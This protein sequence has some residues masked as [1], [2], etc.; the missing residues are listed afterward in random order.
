MKRRENSKLFRGDA[1]NLQEPNTMMTVK[2]ISLLGVLT[3]NG[4]DR[5]CSGRLRGEKQV[6]R[7]ATREKKG[8]NCPCSCNGRDGYRV[9][10]NH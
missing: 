1:P 8:S 3:D 2:E 6:E 4:V 5:A 9:D 10:T 7:A